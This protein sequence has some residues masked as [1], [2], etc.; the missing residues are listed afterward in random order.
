MTSALSPRDIQTRIRSGESLEDVAREAGMPVEKV[1]PFAAPV[2]A[3]REHVANSALQCPVRRR[4]ETG[5]VRAMRTVVQERLATLGIDA[6]EDVAWDAWRNED[7]RWT[8]VARYEDGGTE[9]TA[10]FIFDQR[11]RFSVASDDDARWMIGEYTPAAPGVVDSPDAEPTVD[12]NDELALVRAVQGSVPLVEVPPTPAAP[13]ALPSPVVHARETVV[14]REVPAKDSAAQLPLDE[15]DDLEV[16]DYSPAE[17]EQV[18]GIYDIVPNNTSDMDVL[19]EML[20]SFSEDSV[21]IYA[22]LA[23]PVTSEPV[24]PVAEVTPVEPLLSADEY[25]APRAPAVDPQNDPQVAELDWVDVDEEPIEELD[26]TPA[27]PSRAAGD[28]DVQDNEPPVADHAGD[29]LVAAEGVVEI[30][31]AEPAE[32][33]VVEEVVEDLEAKGLVSDEEVV[34]QIVDDLESEGLVADEVTNRDL[35]E[36]EVEAAPDTAV[37]EIPEPAQPVTEPAV[38]PAEDVPATP[39]PELVET[40][41]APAQPAAKPKAKPRKKRASV[42]SWDEIMFGGPTPKL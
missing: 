27:A 19:Y 9:H 23:N 29:D 16:E 32:E 35:D 18:D 30:E 8:V 3:E 26:E 5:S 15:S 12:L 11:A 31:A 4:G 21:N 2:L 7:R 22:G 33:Q 28:V 1:E 42:P 24:A 20:S 10:T 25:E 14:E 41:E 34:A 38:E 13:K 6:D 17:L 40:P 39:Q 36:A 37:V